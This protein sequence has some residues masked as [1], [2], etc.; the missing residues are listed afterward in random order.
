MCGSHQRASETGW[1]SSL[2][3]AI[4]TLTLDRQGIVWSASGRR[5]HSTVWAPPELL[6][7]CVVQSESHDH[8]GRYIL[9]DQLSM[10]ELGEFDTFAEAE[11][12]FLRF[13]KAEPTA[14][15]QLEI[16]DD[17]DIRLDVDPDKIRAVTAA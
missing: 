5:G 11:A 1:R 6:L 7:A 16:W 4:A 13:A 17:E 2:G 14:V 12:C 8:W 10:N 15:E 3:A 9:L